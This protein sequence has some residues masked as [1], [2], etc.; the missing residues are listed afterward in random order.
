MP[1]VTEQMPELRA[2][3]WAAWRGPGWA[4]HTEA[5]GTTRDPAPELKDVAGTA[6]GTVG[7]L[8]DA[9]HWLGEARPRAGE[10]AGLSLEP[11]LAG[12]SAPDVAD[13]FHRPGTLNSPQQMFSLWEPPDLSGRSLVP[14]G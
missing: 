2:Q 10:E 1:H 5:G 12:L 4:L 7:A 8:E 3:G 6:G 13:A 14:R 11:F 9:G